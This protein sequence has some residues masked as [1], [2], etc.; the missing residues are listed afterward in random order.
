M[1]EETQEATVL[2]T[3]Q[4]QRTHATMTAAQ[5]LRGKGVGGPLSQRSESPG[6]VNDIVELANYIVTG[7]TYTTQTGRVEV[8]EIGLLP[9]FDD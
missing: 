6:A 5:V 3:V 4:Q 8:P 2:N 7:D 9:P 1:P